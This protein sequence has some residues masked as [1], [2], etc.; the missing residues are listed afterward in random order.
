MQELISSILLLTFDMK[1]L[2]QMTINYIINKHRRTIPTLHP[3]ILISITP[4][5]FL[6]NLEILECFKILEVLFFAGNTLRVSQQNQ[7]SVYGIV[8]SIFD[9]NIVYMHP[10][11]NWKRL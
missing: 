6:I 4:Y 3:L 11:F 1:V 10:V 5:F 8:Q 7:S 2:S 9:D